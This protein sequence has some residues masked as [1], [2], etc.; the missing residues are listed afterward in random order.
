MTEKN[1]GPCS[2]A[3]GDNDEMPDVDVKEIDADFS[4]EETNPKEAPSS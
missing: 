1:D 2:E 3:V 4:V